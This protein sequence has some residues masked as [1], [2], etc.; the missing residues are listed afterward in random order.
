MPEPVDKPAA[1]YG[2][3]QIGHLR[4]AELEAVDGI[5]AGRISAFF[6]PKFAVDVQKVVGRA[7]KKYP[8]RIR[9]LEGVALARR[10]A[11]LIERLEAVLTGEKGGEG[12]AQFD[13]FELWNAP[14]N[15]R[16]GEWRETDRLEQRV[17]RPARPFP[18][19]PGFDIRPRTAR[20]IV[21]GLAAED[22]CISRLDVFAE[23]RMRFAIEERTTPGATFR[24]HRL[25]AAGIIS[26]LVIG[27]GK[28][29]HKASG[30]VSRLGQ[31]P[32][33]FHEEQIYVL[34][35]AEPRMPERRVLIDQ[36]IEIFPVSKL[37][38]G[39]IA[40]EKVA[41]PAHFGEEPPQVDQAVAFGLPSEQAELPAANLRLAHG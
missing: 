15:V 33:H 4:A 9:R 26:S 18:Q 12:F 6:I 38:I 21:A 25:P 39:R 36:L 23:K 35:A 20:R 11:L 5:F 34:V 3:D 24:R 7:R 32:H 16:T 41:S 2:K 22:D 29:Y 30:T 31:P 19:R 40:D 13:S 28:R 14:G 1:Q 37:S 27:D 17:A 10:L 8:R